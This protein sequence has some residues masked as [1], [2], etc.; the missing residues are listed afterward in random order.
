M[1]SAQTRARCRHTLITPCRY[2][3]NGYVWSSGYWNA[4]ND[5]HVWQNGHWERQRT[6]Y[7]Y[8][9]PTWSQHDNQWQLQRA[10]WSKADR[11][12]DGVPNNADRAPD[13]PA[14][15]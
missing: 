8:A 6:G 12:G 15:H 7:S 2:A 14:R 9:Q 4:K 10:H 3:R 5:K 13:N 11:D 1:H